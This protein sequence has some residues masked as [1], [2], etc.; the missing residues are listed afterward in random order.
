MSAVKRVLGGAAMAAML[1]ATVA[2]GSDKADQK[3]S[4]D[5]MQAFQECLQQHGVTMP[6]RGGQRPGG[7]ASGR[8][9]GTPGGHPEGAPS[10]RPE[11][12]PSGRPSGM[13]SMSEEQQEAMQA[14][15]SLRPQRGG[16]GPGANGEQSGG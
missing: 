12:V 8:P 2:C 3:P 14:C 4:S 1:L 10:G 7:G 11:D 16:G 5:P 6:D 15:A 9:E 13:P